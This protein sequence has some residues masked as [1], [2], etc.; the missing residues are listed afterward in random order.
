MISGVCCL[1]Y[2][3]TEG[4]LM[5]FLRNENVVL[6]NK[7]KQ[8][9]RLEKRMREGEMAWTAWTTFLCA[10]VEFGGETKEDESQDS[11]S[12]DS[13]KVVVMASARLALYLTLT[14]TG[15]REI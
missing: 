6:R 8:E 7:G 9:V 12:D 11:D 1:D 3:P 2:S 4:Q 15:K 14:N 5:R 13:S 10:H